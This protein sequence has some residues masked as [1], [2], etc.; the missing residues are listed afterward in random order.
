MGG[1]SRLIFLTIFNVLFMNADKSNVRAGGCWLLALSKR[2]YLIN[3][4]ACLVGGTVGNCAQCLSDMAV[5]YIAYA[6][7]KLHALINLECG[8]G[9][10]KLKSKNMSV[11][12]IIVAPHS[13]FRLLSISPRNAKA[14]QPFSFQ[15]IAPTWKLAFSHDCWQLLII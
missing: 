10:A 1:S 9:K 3:F 7:I 4:I 15:L 8:V 13:T 14:L 2:N 6:F 5:K 12:D 11:T